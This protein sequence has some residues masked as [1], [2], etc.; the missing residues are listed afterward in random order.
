[1]VSIHE[2]ELPQITSVEGFIVVIK[3]LTPPTKVVRGTVLTD[4]F[5]L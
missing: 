3:A 1:M 5:F 4:N 2:G